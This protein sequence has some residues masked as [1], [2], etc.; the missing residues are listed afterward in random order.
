MQTI[1]K[2]K[3]NAGYIFSKLNPR[4][5]AVHLLATF[6]LI[7]AARQSVVLS[8]MGFILAVEKYGF[9]DVWNHLVKEADFSARLTYF[10]LWNNLAVLFGL[11]FSFVIS[12][13]LTI[14]RK[15]FWLNAVII[16]LMALLL[17]RLGLF[18][19][20][21]I[22]GIFFSFGD[23]FTGMGLPYKFIANG[24]LLSFIGLF[25]FFSK[26]TL[27]FAFNHKS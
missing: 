13:T 3:T 1:D 21:I 9:P 15:K 4:Q 10:T 24:L 6:F 23:L 5:I 17:N 12:L 7:L 27:G 20:K 11:L 22:D 16:L 18:H 26:W 19:L 2:F 14:K 8:D 25:I